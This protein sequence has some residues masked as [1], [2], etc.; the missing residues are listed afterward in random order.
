[1]YQLFKNLR[2]NWKNTYWSIVINTYSIAFKYRCNIGTLN[3]S[4]N[5]PLIKFSLKIQV[6]MSLQTL[7]VSFKIFAGIFPP[8]VAFLELSFW[9]WVFISSLFTGLN[10]NY[11]QSPVIWCILCILGWFLNFSIAF[12]T[13]TFRS[14]TSNRIPLVSIIFN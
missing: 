11:S 2:Y 13:G 10:S 3:S 12:S 1:M 5:S 4:E 9:I 6:S 8:V 7:E 14:L